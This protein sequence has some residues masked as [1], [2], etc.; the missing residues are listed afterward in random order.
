MDKDRVTVGQLALMLMLVIA[1]GKFLGLPGVLAAEVGH[2]SWLVLCLGFLAD[3]LCLCFL[4]W[5][6][7]I[8]RSACLS[9]DAVLD[10]TVGKAVS[11]A[12]LGIFFVVFTSRMIVLLG[13]CYK[14][15]A[16][17]FDVNTNWIFFALPVAAVSVFA[18][19]RGF[20]SVARVSQLLFMLVTLSVLAMV[21]NPLIDSR[22]TELLPVAEAG[23]GKIALTAVK[24][25]YWFSDYLFVYFL[26]DKVRQGKRLFS[27]VLSVFV[28]GAVITILTNIVFVTLYGSFAEHFD[29]A[30]S[31]LGVFSSG[32]GA[33]GRWDWL[34][35]SLWVTSVLLKITLFFYCAYK[36]LEKMFNL[37]HDKINPFAVCAIVATMM[38]PMAVSGKTFTGKFLAY[39]VAPFAVVQYALPLVFPLLTKIA[40]KKTCGGAHERT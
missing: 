14:M 35:L 13:S 19:W 34:T 27:P 38:I 31:K 8:N 30:M 22:W 40:V 16:V 1:G 18:L 36:S 33:S 32:A 7:R 21:A 26:L 10:V 5:A 37:R 4:L 23:W 28:V 2:D 6:M 11:K 9:V 17:T 29:P 3:A 24:Q 15:F 12:V 20:T 25:G 39:A